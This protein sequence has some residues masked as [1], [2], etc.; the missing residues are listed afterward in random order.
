MA[1]ADL[2]VAFL[3]DAPG[4]VR[5]TLARRPDG[6]WLDMVERTTLDEDLAAADAILIETSA[7][8][9]MRAIDPASI[10]MNHWNIERKTN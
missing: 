9:F 2:E 6:A 10:K 1:A 8:T 3:C 5:R 7:A 4:F